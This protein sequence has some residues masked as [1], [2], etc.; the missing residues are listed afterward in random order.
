MAAAGFDPQDF[1]YIM[2][3]LNRAIAQKN[4]ANLRAILSNNFNVILAALKIAASTPA[5]E[6]A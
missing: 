1:D 2:A 4:E 3:L 6:A 5:K